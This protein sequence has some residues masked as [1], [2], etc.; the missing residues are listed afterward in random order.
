MGIKVNVQGPMFS[1]DLRDKVTRDE[2]TDG[3]DNALGTLRDAI[4]SNAPKQTGQLKAGIKV[5]KRKSGGAVV[6]SKSYGIPVDQGSSPGFA[7]RRGVARLQIWA[8]QALSL[9]PK[10]AR[11]AAYAIN[12]AHSRHGIP[13][14]EFFYK[15]FD[16]IQGS[17]NRQLDPIAAK[18]VAKLEG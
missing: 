6:S 15:T 16:R 1:A 4:I 18:I 3:I 12:K 2:M 14:R 13:K 5:A 8:Q 9:D 10:R 7:S 17:L 11:Q